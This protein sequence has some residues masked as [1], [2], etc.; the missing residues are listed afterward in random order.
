MKI[1]VPEVKVLTETPCRLGESPVWSAHDEALYWVD[2]TAKRLHRFQANE[3]RGWQ[4]DEFVAAAAP[5]VTP[6]HVI[7]ALTQRVVLF[8]VVSETVLELCRPD[9]NPQNRSND[10]R[11]DASGHFWL[12]TM[13]NNLDAQGGGTAVTQA[14]GGVFRIS[15]SGKVEQKLSGIGIT[16]GIAW[17]PDNRT[18]YVADS[19]ENCIYAFDFD[20]KAPDHNPGVHNPSVH[21]RRDFHKGFERGVPDGATVDA[22]GY[23]WSARFG[24]SCLVRHNPDGAID[25]LVELPVSNPTSCAFG[26]DDLATLFVTSATFGLRDEQL[27]SNA[28][29]GTVLSLEVGVKG[30]RTE[31]FAG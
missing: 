11:C 28:L 1:D 4:F 24:G 14:T 23:L 26:G 6:N 27:K 12:G 19:L 13:Q 9:P 29:E 15:A 7:L 17:S 3:E 22:E 8:D 25:R 16:N 20:L 5:C 21:S 10:A 31:Q 18:M 2:I 30:A